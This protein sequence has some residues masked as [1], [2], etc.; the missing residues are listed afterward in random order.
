MPVRVWSFSLCL[1]SH[2]V[3]RF[4][5]STCFKEILSHGGDCAT[6]LNV[7]NVNHY[8]PFLH[9]Y[10][11]LRAGGCKLGFMFVLMGSRS[12]WR[13]VITWVG[14][15]P[16]EITIAWSISSGLNQLW[17]LFSLLRTAAQN[18]FRR[19]CTFSIELLGIFNGIFDLGS[20]I[21]L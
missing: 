2:V 13:R 7:C 21:H 3:N 20:Q 5:T 11:R 14:W 19:S 17:T 10:L 4:V 1:W 18:A 6:P 16:V 12:L 15:I 8:S 9:L